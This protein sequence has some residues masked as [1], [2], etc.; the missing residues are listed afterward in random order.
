MPFD[1]TQPKPGSK[2]L[3]APIRENFIALKSLIDAIPAGP[4]GPAGA[5][6]DPGDPGPAGPAGNDGAPGPAGAQGERG[7][8]GDKGD[9][10]D[11]GGPPGPQGPPGNDGAPGAEGP[12]GPEGRHI[13]NVWDN[14]DGR[15]VVQMSDGSSYGP[16][17]IASGPEG[18]Q[19]PQGAPGEVSAA[20]LSFAIGGTSANSNSVQPLDTTFA[21]PDMETL[22]QKINELIQALRR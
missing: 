3:S 21:N 14:G 20:D 19:G 18:P 6:G 16:F 8:K 10:G 5:K 11:P 13:T 17:T 15:A 1:P 2:K 22:R 4:A 12:A 9:P 7:D